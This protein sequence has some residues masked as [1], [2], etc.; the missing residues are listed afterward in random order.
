MNYEVLESNE[1]WWQTTTQY[2][3][4][5]DD[6]DI[7]EFRAAEDPKGTE[8]FVYNDRWEELDDGNEKHNIFYDAWSEGELD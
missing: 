4:R 7:I 1:V 6:G 5:F 2:K 8:F 3:I